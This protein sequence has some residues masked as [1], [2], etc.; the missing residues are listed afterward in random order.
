MQAL[1]YFV[2]LIKVPFY[3]FPRTNTELQYNT[4]VHFLVTEKQGNQSMAS[5]L[6]IVTSLIDWEL[7]FQNGS[8]IHLHINILF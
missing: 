7:K 4:I 3:Y 8:P 1:Q 2:L 6:V 5:N